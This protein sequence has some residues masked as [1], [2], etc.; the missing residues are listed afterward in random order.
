[1]PHH[2]DEERVIPGLGEDVTGTLPSS[3]WSQALP[4]TVVE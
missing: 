1:M 4:C 3:A 2:E